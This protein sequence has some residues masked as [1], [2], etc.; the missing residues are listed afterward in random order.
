MWEE[1]DVCG[2]VDID[3]MVRNDDGQEQHIDDGKGDQ[4]LKKSTLT[5]KL[6]FVNEMCNEYL[7]SKFIGMVN[8]LRI[9]ILN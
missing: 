6:I 1:K 4:A 5:Y 9:L 2:G 7:I 8:F 3:A